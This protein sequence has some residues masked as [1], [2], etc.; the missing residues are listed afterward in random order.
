MLNVAWPEASRLALP[1]LVAPSKKVTLPVGVPAA[2]ATAE[3]VAVSMMLCP[4]TAGLDEEAKAVA[5][6]P[7]FT[8][9]PVLPL[10]APLV[11][12]MVVLPGVS[13]A[14]RPVPSMLA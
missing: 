10:M 6:E 3:M 5:V 11:A 2:G 12:V 13:A 1:K 4:D 8:V 7:G 14:A 9:R